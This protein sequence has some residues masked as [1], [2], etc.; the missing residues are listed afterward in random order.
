MRIVIDGRM[1]FGKLHGIA[2]YIYEMLRVWQRR[3]IEEDILILTNR[4]D[5]LKELG[6]LN[7]FAYYPVNSVPFDPKEMW[8]IPQVLKKIGGDV[9]HAPSISVPPSKV[10]PTVITVHDLIPCH[11]GG[12]VHKV[13]CKTVLKRALQYAKAIITPSH[14]T[15]EDVMKSF[16]I[17]EDKIWVIY[18]AATGIPPDVPSW[19]SVKK[20]YGIKE[21]FIFYLG[22]PKPHKNLLGVIDIYNLLRK[23]IDYPVYLVIGSK[24]SEDVLYSLLHSP[25]RDDIFRIDY[26]EEGELHLLY[27]KAEV[28]V[29]PSLFEGFG[30]PPLEAMARGTPVVASNRTSLKEVV[31]D[32][33]ILA[34]PEDLEKFACEIKKLLEDKNYK[35]KWAEKGKEWERRFSWEKC[36][37]ETLKVYRKVAEA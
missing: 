22:N 37:M 30:L 25:F 3:G 8:E 17:P 12:V 10:M 21:P 36:A 27:T 1:I 32:G 33:G 34:D 19:D 6:F 4:E 24:S 23:K 20:K 13:Y 7:D 15:K 29:F 18:E 35:K 28:F 2:R 16:D 9:F 26:L 14:F 5:V 11:G 31:G